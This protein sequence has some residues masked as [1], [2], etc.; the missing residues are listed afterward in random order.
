[1]HVC[2]AVCETGKTTGLEK[3]CAILAKRNPKVSVLVVVRLQ[4]QEDRTVR[5]INESAGEDV[6]VSVHTGGRKNDPE[7]VSIHEKLEYT[8]ES[9]SKARETIKNTQIVI[10]THAADLGSLS[11]ASGNTS[12]KRWMRGKRQ[13]RVVD[14]ALDLI[15]RHHLNMSE[16]LEVKCSFDTHRIFYLGLNKEYKEEFKFLNEVNQRISEMDDKRLGI[17]DH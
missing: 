6:T 5:E 2:V 17:I 7:R 11:N 16:L 9:K 4:Q 12:F 8:Q 10:I 1:M 13:F 14:E 3:A 15:E